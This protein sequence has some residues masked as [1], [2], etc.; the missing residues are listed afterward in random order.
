MT[1]IAS[2]LLATT[3]ALGAIADSGPSLSGEALAARVR[4]TLQSR[5]VDSGS[6]ATLQM[7]G[8]MPDQALA[9]GDV[10]VEVGPVAGRWPRA[11]ANVPVRIVVDGRTVSRLS[12]RVQASDLRTVLGY[13]SDFPAGASQVAAARM[14]IDM[15]CCEGAVVSSPQE[16]QGMRLRRAVSTGA[17]V[18]QGD[19]EPMPVVSTRQTVSVAVERGR[20]RI[21]APGI[22]L[23]DGQLGDRIAVRTTLSQH[24]ISARVVAAGEVIVD[25]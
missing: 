16:L 4:D 17:P 14:V 20:I 12:A 24:A 19:L 22:A 25:E 18:L 8:R 10:Q 9:S 15:V 3:A 5:L 2:F 1:I 23:Q 11:Q 6:T 21:L 7:V 13:S